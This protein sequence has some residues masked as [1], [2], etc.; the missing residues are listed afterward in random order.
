[1]HLDSH[2]IFEAYTP[3]ELGVVLIPNYNGV[4]NADMLQYGAIKS[5]WYL[6][7]IEEECI[8]VSNLYIKH[9]HDGKWIESEGHRIV[10]RSDNISYVFSWWQ[11][12][13]DGKTRSYYDD[14]MITCL[15][16]PKYDKT[17]LYRVAKI[18]SD[19]RAKGYTKIKNHLDNI[20][21]IWDKMQEDPDVAS[22]YDL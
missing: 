4:V 9:K 21:V 6:P 11:E 19:L 10:N 16:L 5:T 22:L 13:L 18:W 8:A 15:V 2:L 17:D 1:M 20:I 14:D 7:K 3:S 12:T